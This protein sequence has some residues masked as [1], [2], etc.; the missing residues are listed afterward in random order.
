[1]LKMRCCLHI[2]KPQQAQHSTSAA[3]QQTGRG[4]ALGQLQDN[5]SLHPLRSTPGSA[6]QP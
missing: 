1:M 5:L 6:R 4:S 3:R 2:N